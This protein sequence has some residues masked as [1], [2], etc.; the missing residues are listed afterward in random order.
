VPVTVNGQGPFDFLLDTGAEVTVIDKKVAKKLNLRPMVHTRLAHYTGT[1][2]VPLAAIESMSVGSH[3]VQDMKVLYFDL[4]K[5]WD[6]DGK[7]QGVLGQDYL[8]KFNYLISCKEKLILFERDGDLGSRAIGTRL[9]CE[10][11]AGKLYISI[12]FSSGGDECRRFLLDSG[13]PYLLVYGKPKDVTDLDI[14]RV[15]EE[16]VAKTATGRRV[17][18]VCRIGAFKIG[19]IILKGLR[20]RLTPSGAGGTRYSDGLLPIHI[21]ESVY[22]NSLE[23]YVILNPQQ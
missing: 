2:K 4:K 6:F 15:E 14:I 5:L 1:S 10:R 16:R 8:S 21:F 22:V 11:D 7:I 3:T 18:R 20:V 9:P 12:P 19:D 23:S 13:S 17:L